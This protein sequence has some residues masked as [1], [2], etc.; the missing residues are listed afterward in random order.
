[1]IIKSISKVTHVKWHS[2]YTY[3]TE[4]T[5]SLF[6]FSLPLSEFSFLLSLF[7]EGEFISISKLTSVE[8]MQA[9]NE[10]I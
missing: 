9:L 1:M 6:S 2:G 8:A 4:K 7:A 3:E 10:W 5:S